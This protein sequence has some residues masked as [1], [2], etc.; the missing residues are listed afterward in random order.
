[1][2]HS[3]PQRIVP[4][5]GDELVA[6]QHPDGVIYVVFA[7][8]CDNLGLL[9]HGQARRVQQ[10]A[11][12]NEGFTT[13]TV[14]TEGG[15]QEAQCLRLDLLP[16]W[17]SGI[18]AKRVKPHLQEKLVRYQ[19]EAA[20]A[21]WHAFKPQILI[22]EETAITPSSDTHAMQQLQQIADMGR[23]ITR[24]AE[25]HME[26][27]RQQQALATRMDAAARVIRGVQGEVL[28]VRGEV[29]DLGIRLGV[30]EDRV[31]PASFI[32]E[33]QAAE[34]SQR[35]KALADLLNQQ[36]KGKNHYQGIFQ[37]LYRRFGVASYKTIVHDQYGAVL[38]F[39]DDWRRTVA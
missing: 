26:L 28:A 18:Q 17:M 27:Q 23:A 11:V 22:E 21:L 16:L 36:E 35:V 12:L 15:P 1:M 32:T 10:H 33:G 3:V 7:R 8:L 37:E 20:A 4:F 24:M 29:A 39:L 30:L 13:L 2:A 19:R 5:Y 34:I 6:V 31:Q 9:R 25:Q 14:Q 38:A